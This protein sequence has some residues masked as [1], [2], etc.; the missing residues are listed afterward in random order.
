MGKVN[1]GRVEKALERERHRMIWRP[2]GLPN[3]G[4]PTTSVFVDEVIQ[5]PW[6]VP[7]RMLVSVAITGAFLMPTDNPDQPITV[8]QIRDEA[9]AC[10]GDGASTIHIH[11]RDDNGYNTLSLERFAAVISPL[12]EQY[13]DLAV[14]G[15]LVPALDGEWDEMRR[16]LESGLLDAVPVNTTATYVG[17]ALFAKP[18]PVILEKTRLVREAGAK[19]IIACYVDGDISNADRF[20]FKSG[21]VESPSYWLILP[22]LPGC[23]PMANPRQMADGLLRMSS[24]IYDVDPYATVMVCAAGRASTWLVAL[25][26]SLGLHIRVGMEDTLWRWPH[27][28]DKITSNR[29]MLGAAKDIGALLGRQIASHAEYR[30]MVGMQD[31]RS[32]LSV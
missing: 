8:D 4:S 6:R 3:V 27:R 19:V 16:V 25:A 11:V 10:A 21:L 24:A 9:I 28:E 31:A 26:A 17:D 18:I 1:W 30:S 15:C 23:S 13:P 32:S 5:P 20:L 29:V 14:D 2:Y 12:R 7:D 22:A